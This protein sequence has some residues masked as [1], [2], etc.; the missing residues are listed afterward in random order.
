[1]GMALAGA[2]LFAVPVAYYAWR[3]S[4]QGKSVTYM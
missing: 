3:R 4:R 2:A 1:M